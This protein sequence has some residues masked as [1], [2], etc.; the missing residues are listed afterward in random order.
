M[1]KNSLGSFVLILTPEKLL[2]KIASK[3]LYILQVYLILATLSAPFLN[4]LLIL[5][6]LHMKRSMVTIMLGAS[7]S[8]FAWWLHQ[9]VNLYVVDQKIIACKGFQSSKIFNIP[10]ASSLFEEVFL[11]DKRRIRC[12]LIAVVACLCSLEDKFSCLDRPDTTSEDSLVVSVTKISVFGS[13][14]ID[15]W[16]LS[17][18]RMKLPSSPS[19]PRAS[20]LIIS[21]ETSRPSFL[22]SLMSRLRR[23]I[24]TSLAI[25]GSLALI[26]GGTTR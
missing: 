25:L 6:Q 4:A 15:T 24:R 9:S 1:F 20:V 21:P 22:L 13:R 23:S 12:V 19:Y 14:N 26:G 3:P 7:L 5:I 18:L 16:I 17:Y 11:W 8:C 2:L 10:Q